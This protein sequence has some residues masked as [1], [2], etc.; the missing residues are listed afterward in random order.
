VRVQ[1]PPSPSPPFYVDK[2]NILKIET[3]NR[4]DHQVAITV[5]L[6]NEQ[7]ENARRR[8]ARKIALHAK[9]PGFRP[10]KA[11]YD[12]ILRTV[13]EAT[14]S[15][16]AVELLVDEIY[17]K[18][19]DESGIKPAAAGTLEEITSVEPPIFKFLIP[20]APT[21][22][23]GAYRSTRVN[24]DWEPPTEDKV[25]EK[26]EELRRMYS[27]TENVDRAIQKGDFVIVDIKGTKSKSTEDE[28]PIIDRPG[29]PV[30]IRFDE[31]QDEWPFTGFSN[32]LLGMNID[33]DRKFSHKYPKD[34]EDE[35]LCG[36]SVNF[37]VKVKTIR[38]T[39]LPDLNDEFSKRV[40]NF[41]NVSLLR[42][43]IRANLINQSKAEYD[44]EF[45]EKVINKIKENATIKYPPQALEHESEHVLEDLK[46]RLAAKNIELDVYIKMRK[47]EKEKFLEEEVTPV[48]IRRLERSLI[49]D[50]IAVDE[51]IE[52]S[53]EYLNNAFQQIWLELQSDEQYQKIMKNKNKPSK[54][55]MESIAMESAS[56]AMI[57][58]TLDRLKLIAIGEAV[59]TSESADPITKK[60]PVKRKPKKEQVVK[61]DLQNES[62]EKSE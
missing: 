19:L 61:T 47:L 15:E 45:F 50:Q 27:N 18:V 31:K 32:K 39:I 49:M 34:L 13:G 29:N 28:K 46:Q 37:E 11:P 58:Q 40:G 62:V 2:D 9:I 1:I 43:G 57:R 4:D 52:V 14:I 8:A 42:D 25:D 30:F 36:N 51:K 6:E 41:E 35:D 21:I 26:I 48:A 7:M 17:P 33:E 23:L 59:E 24:Y 53:E 22:D 16:E 54:K 60:A 56:R 3:Q 10:G 44:D 12:V 5:E 55:L 20:L 38:G